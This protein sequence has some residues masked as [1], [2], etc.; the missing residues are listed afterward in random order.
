MKIFKTFAL[1]SLL[2]IAATGCGSSSSDEMLN[3]EGSEWVLIQIDGEPILPGSKTTLIFEVDRIHGKGGCND[4]FASYSL[5]EDGDIEFGLAGSTMMFCPDPEGVM[6]QE[7]SFLQTLAEVS[8]VSMEGGLL[9][10][11]DEAGVSRLVFNQI[12]VD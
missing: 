4:Y 9:I 11:K 1:L 3:L 2:V 8:S 5:G 12:L 6:D 7:F 10:L